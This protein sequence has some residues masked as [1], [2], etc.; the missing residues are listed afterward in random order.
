MVSGELH[1]PPALS[2]EKESPGIHW[3]GDWMGPRV[4]LDAVAKRKI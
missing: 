1:A 3:V 2:P 4:G